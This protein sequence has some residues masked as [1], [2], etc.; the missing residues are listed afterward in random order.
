MSSTLI[1]VIFPLQNVSGHR[2]VGCGL[3]GQVGMMTLHIDPVH[4][5]SEDQTPAQTYYGQELGQQREEQETSGAT[6]HI[7]NVLAGKSL[8]SWKCDMLFYLCL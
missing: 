1:E 8:L 6:L 5:I 4:S 2:D 7:G 3:A